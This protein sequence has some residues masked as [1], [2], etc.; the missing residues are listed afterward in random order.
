MARSP[1]EIQIN[2]LQSDLRQSIS[3]ISQ[4]NSLIDAY[5]LDFYTDDHWTLLSPAWR[6]TFDQLDLN[7]LPDVLSTR[8]TISV[9]LPLSLLALR[10]CVHRLSASRKV[11]PSTLV[12]KTAH[13]QIHLYKQMKMKKCH[14]IDRMAELSAAT[15]RK[16]N[17]KYL[18]DFGAGLGHLARILSFQHGLR[19]CCLEQDKTL[20]TEA[21]LVIEW[22][23]VVRDCI[24]VL[25]SL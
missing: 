5:A 2:R 16:C 18:V 10:K 7:V 11:L 8:P 1:R 24:H 17:V 21:R 9:V 15:A 20:S 12:R 6:S 13:C 22:R 4:F 23:R 19:V 3:V 25:S 14:E